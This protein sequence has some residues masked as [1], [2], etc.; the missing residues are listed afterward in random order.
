M[1]NNELPQEQYLQVEEVWNAFVEQLQKDAAMC[2]I[3]LNTEIFSTNSLRENI[4]KISAVLKNMASLTNGYEKIQ[5]WLYRV[6]VPEQLI[7]SKINQND[8][9][10]NIV[11]EL[12][13]KRTLQKVVIR[14]LYKH[15]KL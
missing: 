9:Y 4:Q 5:T 15:D 11:A 10:Y 13:L 6:D 1:V 2:G 8:D 7:K 12:I 14:Y 3:C